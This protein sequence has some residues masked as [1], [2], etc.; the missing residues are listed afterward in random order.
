[1]PLTT[2]VSAKVRQE[3]HDALTDLMRRFPKLSRIDAVT[4]MRLLTEKATTAEQREMVDRVLSQRP[5]RGRPAIANRITEFA[6]T[7]ALAAAG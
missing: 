3:D 1:M 6:D 5:K 4:V 7:S 2:E